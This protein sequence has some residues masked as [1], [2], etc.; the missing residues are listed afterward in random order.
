[1]CSNFLYPVIIL[2]YF[3]VFIGIFVLNFS[4]HKKKV[5]DKDKEVI[6]PLVSYPPIPEEEE[7]QE[8]EEDAPL[9]YG[10]Q[11]PPDDILEKLAESEP[12]TESA[13]PSSVV[14]PQ[15]LP[16][17]PKEK[18]AKNIVAQGDVEK[19][20]VDGSS[21]SKKHHRSKS[22]KHSVE[23]EDVE[24]EKH[25]DAKSHDSEVRS[26]EH[27][28]KSQ[29][30]DAKSVSQSSPVTDVCVSSSTGVLIGTS[31][32]GKTCETSVKVLPH[33]DVKDEL[34]LPPVGEAKMEELEDEEDF[35]NRELEEP[36]FTH[37]EYVNKKYEE[38]QSDDV[39]LGVEDIDRELELALERRMVCH[40]NLSDV[41]F[42]TVLDNLI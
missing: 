9:I 36:I 21:T 24:V 1:M 11:K 29:Y 32:D 2:T 8:A 31:D 39:D 4:K 23:T 13:E 10:P 7:E 40:V 42:S 22:S 12:I 34:V 25:Q 17:E 6:E 35:V 27:K 19:T 30:R 37:Y 15:T 28:S 41:L 16:P 5:D 20:V 18:A 38:D 33:G 26:S 3:D 14:E